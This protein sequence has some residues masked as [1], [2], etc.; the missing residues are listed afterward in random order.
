[1][2]SHTKERPQTVNVWAEG[3]GRTYEL[4]REEVARR[5]KR[6]HR[7]KL[8]NLHDSPNIIKVRSNQE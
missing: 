3:A 4:K 8:N 7:E 5:W 2:A 6:L 1:M